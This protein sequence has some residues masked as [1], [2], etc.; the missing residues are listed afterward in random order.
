MYMH[1]Y[2][3][4][5]KYSSGQN[6]VNVRPAYNGDSPK[7]NAKRT[8]DG[9]AFRRTRFYWSRFYKFTRAFF[10]RSAFVFREPREIA[11]CPSRSRP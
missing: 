11:K 10:I 2:M 8:E 3:Y 6:K 4:M 5:K 1:M 9:N 7:T